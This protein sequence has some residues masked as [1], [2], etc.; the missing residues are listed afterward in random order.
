MTS[1]KRSRQ[2]EWMDQADLDPDLHRTALNGLG[3][4]NWISRTVSSV[5]APVFQQ[6]RGRTTP[7]TV[8]DV[9]CGG[10]DLAVGLAE[11]ARAHGV[12]IA[13]EGCDISQTALTKARAQAKARGLDARFF[14]HDVL[15]ERLP[16]T[17]DVIVCSLFLHHVDEDQAEHLLQSWHVAARSLLVLSDLN[18]GLL[19]LLFA[20]VGAR[21]LSRSPIV[22]VDAV[23]S[24]HAAYTRA[25]VATLA[26]R[27]GLASPRSRLTITPQWP[28][29]WRLTAEHVR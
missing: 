14:Q 25:E 9:A 18:R 7:L 12:P 24:A 27:A 5:W 20:W 21:L 2:P 22:H 8:L 26:A 6:L 1:M 16:H 29:R 11:R 28:C 10:G 4:I 15:R 3:R 13:V 17:Y 19:G 23:R